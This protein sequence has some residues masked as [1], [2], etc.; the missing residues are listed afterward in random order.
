MNDMDV[1]PVNMKHVLREQGYILFYKRTGCELMGRQLDG[2]KEGK[3]EEKNGVDENLL[4]NDYF[5]NNCNN[6]NSELRM[7]A[8]RVDYVKVPELATRP[9]LKVDGKKKVNGDGNEVVE[10]FWPP[11]NLE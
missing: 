2:I 10:I 6:K 1:I 5:T 3:N 7:F 8:D 4:T 11:M 9:E